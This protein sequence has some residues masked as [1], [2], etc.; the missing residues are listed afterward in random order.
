VRI[1]DIER[2]VIAFSAQSQDETL[3]LIRSLR[4]FDVQID[5]VPRL[6]E[7]VGPNVGIHTVEGLALVGL[8]PLRLSRSSLLIKRTMDL[9]LSVLGLLALAPVLGFIALRVKLDSP[10]PILYRHDRIGKNGEPFRLL[11]FRTMHLESCR[12][13]D[14]GADAAEAAFEE[15]MRTPSLR[16]EFDRTQKLRNDPRVTGF[17]Q[18]LRQASLDELPQLLN[19]ITGDISLVGPRAI[20][21]SE[22]NRLTGQSGLSGYWEIKDLRPG[23]TGYWQINGRSEIN[24][25]DRVQLE[26][27]YVAGWSLKLDLIILAKTVRVLLARTGAC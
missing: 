18:F 22:C 3:K 11:K 24:W 8:P 17:G 13:G 26:T 5:I 2:V 10:G 19:V 23:I 25:D 12:G 14:Y 21:A 6:F 7:I 27:A 16:E 1:F 15:L 20:T 4:D 9:I